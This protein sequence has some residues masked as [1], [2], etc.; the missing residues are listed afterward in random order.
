MA[1]VEDRTVLAVIEPPPLIV[2]IGDPGVPA[3]QDVRPP[4]SVRELPV[5]LTVTE[6]GLTDRVA[7]ARSSSVKL[8]TTDRPPVDE[9]PWL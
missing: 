3:V 9:S 8:S 6:E 2:N 7:V 4:V 5:V 1:E